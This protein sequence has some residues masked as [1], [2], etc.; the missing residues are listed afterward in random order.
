MTMGS[1]VLLR[2]RAFEVEI[3]AGHQTRVT[4]VYKT[5]NVFFFCLLQR[6]KR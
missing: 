6:V 3:T 1:V 4:A 2:L 5:I